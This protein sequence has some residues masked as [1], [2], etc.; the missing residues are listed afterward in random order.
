MSSETTSAT[1]ARSRHTNR[2]SV[3]ALACAILGTAG[4]FWFGAAGFVTFGVG[5]GHVSLH[6][7]KARGERGA[8]LAY[9]A[10]AV[11]YLIATWALVFGLY[12]VIY[13]LWAPPLTEV[14][15]PTGGAGK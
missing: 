9:I 6:Q 5:A 14:F 12:P 4:G 11:C 7:I 3:V 2:L 1:S 8:T 13:S 10:L 15:P